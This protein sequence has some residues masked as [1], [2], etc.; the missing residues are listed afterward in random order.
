[1]FK[2]CNV[3]GPRFQKL[4]RLDAAQKCR[5]QFQRP[6]CDDNNELNRVSSRSQ[7]LERLHKEGQDYVQHSARTFKYPSLFHQPTEPLR[8]ADW[9]AAMNMSTSEF[10]RPI[11]SDRQR[12]FTDVLII[13]G[14]AVGSSVAYALKTISRN[15]FKVTVLE[16]DSQVQLHFVCFYFGINLFI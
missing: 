4:N 5:M 7:I 11:G 13:G 6:F 12:N 8:A 10:F 14:G 15:T 16:R 2:H 1:M 9:K 3:I